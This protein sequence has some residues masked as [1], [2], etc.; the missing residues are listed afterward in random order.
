MV[1]LLVLL[2]RFPSVTVLVS[3]CLHI[4]RM[5]QETPD[6]VGNEEYDNGGLSGVLDEVLP[7]LLDDHSARQ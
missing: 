5:R 6:W 7:L 2:D 1:A 3:C 4:G